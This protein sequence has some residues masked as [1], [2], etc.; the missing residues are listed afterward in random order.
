MTLPRETE[1]SRVTKE[2]DIT[3]KLNID[4]TGKAIIKTGIGFFD[5][6][7]NTLILHSRFD[8]ELIAKGDLDIDGHHLC[9]DVGITLGKALNDAIGEPKIVRFGYALVPMDDALVVCSIDI[10][11]RPYFECGNLIEDKFIGTFQTEW[12]TEFLRAFALNGKMNLHLIRF[13]GTNSHHIAECAMKS[14]ALSLKEA[15][16][17]SGEVPSTKGALL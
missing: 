3:I 9:E 6:M 8:I 13:R 10:S 2:T 1:V 4:G 14:L 11:G 15:L 16:K 12:L 5:H 7:L 17:K